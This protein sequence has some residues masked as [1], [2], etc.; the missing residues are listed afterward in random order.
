[1]GGGRGRARGKGRGERRKGYVP[2]AEAADCAICQ[3]A[4]STYTYHGA[5]QSH[6]YAP[7]YEHGR[8]CPGPR[9]VECTK[10]RRK[11]GK[12]DI[13]E[14]HVTIRTC[15]ENERVVASTG[16]LGRV[17]DRL[18]LL[19]NHTEQVTEK[20][21]LTSPHVSPVWGSQRA[22]FTLTCPDF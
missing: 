22:T 7:H 8:A 4:D 9:G 16:H 2:S 1:M 17:A 18:H 14:K 12:K 3:T 10:R 21:S 11:G 6:A 15:A 20:V 19:Y 5:N 13:F